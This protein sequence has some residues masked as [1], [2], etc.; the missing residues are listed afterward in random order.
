MSN[1][2]TAD[3][4]A[5]EGVESLR[6]VTMAIPAHKAPATTKE[7]QTLVSKKKREYSADPEP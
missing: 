7:V 5:E 6:R 2:D 1:A 4:A 3:E